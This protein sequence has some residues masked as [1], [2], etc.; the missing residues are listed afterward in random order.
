[1]RNQ[2]PLYIPILFWHFV[3]LFTNAVPTLRRWAP[4]IYSYTLV[5]AVVTLVSD[6][7]VYHPLAPT[8][9]EK[10]FSFGLLYRLY[11]AHFFLFFPL[12][13]LLLCRAYL[14][15]E[16]RRFKRSAL[17]IFAGVLASV[18]IGLMGNLLLPWFGIFQF[19]WIANLSSILYICVIMYA[20]VQYRLFN[21]K[22]VAIE[23]LSAFLVGFLIVDLFFSQVKTAPYVGP[24]FLTLIALISA[25]QVRG[26]YREI[27]QR[28]V[29]EKQEKDLEIANAGQV[30]LIHILNHQIKGFLTKGRNTISEVLDGV[31]GPVPEKAKPILS[32]GLD[33]LTEGVQFTTNLLNVSSVVGGTMRYT[34][35]PMDLRAV[36]EE[37][38]AVEKERAD[39]K[40]LALTVEIGDGS[41]HMTGDAVQ[42]RE[43]VKNLI[44]NAIVYTPA[45]SVAVSLVRKAD[46]IVLS[47]R[48][49]GVGITMEDK[50]KLFTEGGRGKEAFKI[51]PESTGYGLS[52]VKGVVAAHHD[53]VWAESEGVGK[54]AVF[55]VEVGMG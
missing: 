19:D 25:L 30:N 29:I 20:I 27:A 24:M 37:V 34:M 43:V 47:V 10:T 52:F 45:G 53:T 54:G 2:V 17:S 36:V 46:H 42:L 13:F 38:A 14:K 49:T 23:F 15:S 33:A 18:T 51:N 16:D 6:A 50:A 48:D 1:M 39:K 35:A 32:E 26:V 4:A 55:V 12:A 28:E 21:I 5:F 44:N 7:V 3:C 9:G 41:Y 11:V 8:I 31:Y 40:G 22:V